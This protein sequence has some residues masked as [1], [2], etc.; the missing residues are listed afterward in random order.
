MA[1]LSLVGLYGKELVLEVKVGCRST[2]LMKGIREI[3]NN[4]VGF[5]ELGA[6]LREIVG[7]NVVFTEGGPSSLLNVR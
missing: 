1:L 4:R 5:S 6:E 2:S 3:C 7:S